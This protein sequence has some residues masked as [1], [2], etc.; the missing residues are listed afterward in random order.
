MAS[1]RWSCAGGA[2]FCGAAFCHNPCSVSPRFGRGTPASPENAAAL[3]LRILLGQDLHEHSRLCRA[4]QGAGARRGAQESRVPGMSTCCSFGRLSLY[5]PRFHR[6]S[7][8]LTKRCQNY[9]VPDVVLHV[10]C[11]GLSQSHRSLHILYLELSPVPVPQTS[12]FC[13][14]PL[15]FKGLFSPTFNQTHQNSIWLSSPACPPTPS[16]YTATEHTPAAGFSPGP[17]EAEQ[18]NC[19]ALT[20]ACVNLPEL[21]L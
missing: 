21:P 20:P 13:R 6:Y 4:F 18:S 16:L 12:V 9:T 7:P 10:P 8:G 19:C 3:A 15:E 17:C 11:L 2:A 5:P 1:S 14:D